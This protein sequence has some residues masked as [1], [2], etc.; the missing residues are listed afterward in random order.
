ME[1]QEEKT[2]T[3]PKCG[4]TMEKVDFQSIVVDRCG[5]CHGMWFD[6]LEH[7]KLKQLE[8]SESIDDGDPAVG[9]TFDK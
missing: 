1:R 8:G 9:K 6:N 5:G 7:E 3:C 2:L 4:S